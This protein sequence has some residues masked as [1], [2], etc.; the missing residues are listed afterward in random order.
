MI[1]CYYTFYDSQNTANVCELCFD[2]E[3]EDVLP[4][5]LFDNTPGERRSV[6]KD[7]FDWVISGFMWI[8]TLL[9]PQR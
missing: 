5:D 3:S 8:V 1:I 9:T 4:G 2:L 7:P 6:I